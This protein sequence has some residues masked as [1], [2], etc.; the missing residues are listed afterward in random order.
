[1]P[2]MKKPKRTELLTT[3]EVAERLGVSEVRIQT[4]LRTTPA[5]RPALVGGKRRW[6]PADVEQLRQRLAELEGRRPT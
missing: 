5:L 6:S 4:V 2:A 3:G 1:M